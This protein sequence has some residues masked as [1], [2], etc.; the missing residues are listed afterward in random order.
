M[1]N[2][3]L[4]KEFLEEIINK[5]FS[6]RKI[7]YLGKIAKY[8]GVRINPLYRLFKGEKA[9]DSASFNK[10]ESMNKEFEK[11]EFYEN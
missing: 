2:L 9:L 8:S 7:G 10:L 4:Q 3:K 1:K 5:F 6:S 11:G